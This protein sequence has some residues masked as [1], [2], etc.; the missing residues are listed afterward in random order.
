MPELG[1]GEALLE[2]RYLGIDPT[3][4]GWL[5]ERGNYMAGVGDRRGG[6]LERRRRRRRDQQTR[7][8][9]LG[10]AFMQLT[11]WQEYCVVESNPFPPITMVPEDVELIDV[12]SVLGH[13]GL[14]AYLGV[15]EVAQAAGGRDVP[16]CRR[17]RAASASI[18]GPDRQAA[19]RARDRHRGLAREVRVGRRRARL[20]RV[21]R[22]QARRRR[23]AARRSS[24]RRASTSSSTTSAANCSTPCCAASRC[25]AASCCAATSRRYN[26]DG[27]AAAAAQH[28]LPHGQAGAHGGLQHPRPL[29]RLRRRGR[30]SSPRGSPTGKIKHK[31]DVLDGLE[32]APEALVRLFSR[33]PPRQARREGRAVSRT[34]SRSGLR[35]RVR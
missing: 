3:I 30:S 31:L 17:P 15:L 5:D 25:T 19:G 1:D 21:H 35:L 34:L 11:G 2:V 13:I 26:L 22:L 7:E 9:P 27:A 28:A 29:G 14:T 4:R 20:R 18:A 12:L 33:R 6:A 8:Y 10:R 24:R 16:A 23:G 32:R